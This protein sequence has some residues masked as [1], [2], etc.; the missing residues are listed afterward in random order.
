LAST[1]VD[2]ANA[3]VELIGKT[4]AL[5]LESLQKNIEEIDVTIRGV[6]AEAREKIQNATTFLYTSQVKVEKTRALLENLAKDT[7]RRVNTMLHYLS[8]V[9]DDWKQDKIAKFMKFQ[10]K[11]MTNLVERSLSLVKDAEN[12][13]Q[14]TRVSLAEIKANL[15]EF[16]KFLKILANTNSDAFKSESKAIRSEV[17]PPC[18][19]PCP[20][21]CIAVCVPIVETKISEWKTDLNKL[22]T[23]IQANSADVQSLIHKTDEQ[24]KVLGKEVNVLINWG[25]ALHR[26]S[27][28]NYEFPELELFE[29]VDVRPVITEKLG[30]LKKAA[31]NYLSIQAHPTI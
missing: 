15:E 31:E 7:V 21:C 30:D 18:C 26:M 23:I 19:I 24:N 27:E 14:E 20:L 12:L 13:F 10:A 6:T 5:Y 4:R 11:D 1:M 8:L 28:V 9:K 25:E 3:L 29:F 16:D 22:L 17:Y 2:T